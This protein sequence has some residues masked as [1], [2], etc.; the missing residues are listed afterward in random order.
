MTSTVFGNGRSSI[1]SKD[2]L[3]ARSSV[4]FGE[5]LASVFH[6]IRQMPE[7]P[8]AIQDRVCNKS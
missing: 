4:K 3:E 5:Y 8:S 7:S 1:Q 6:F 2:L